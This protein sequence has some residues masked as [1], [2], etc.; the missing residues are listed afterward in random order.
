MKFEEPSFDVK[1]YWDDKIL[2]QAK[3]L[4]KEY[5]G[6]SI[7]FLMRKLKVNSGMAFRIIK[8]LNT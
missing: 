7:P 8:I 5:G 4:K 6:L 3:T 2:D 1:N